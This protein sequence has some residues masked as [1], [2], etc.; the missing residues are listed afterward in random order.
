M[1]IYIRVDL[2]LHV[3]QR[4]VSK[5]ILI[6]WQS[7]DLDI[8]GSDE[9]DVELWQGPPSESGQPSTTPHARDSASSSQ[10]Q[11]VVTAHV[12]GSEIYRVFPHHV[13]PSTFAS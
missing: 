10:V 4:V 8:T 2:P 6:T 13:R 12:H 11:R 9:P 3:T 1:Y 7:R 5:Y